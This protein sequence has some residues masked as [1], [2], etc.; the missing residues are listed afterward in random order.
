M[1]SGDHDLVVPF[2]STQAWIRALNYSIVDDWRPWFVNGQV[3][4]YTRTY[5]NGMTFSTVKGSG[6]TAAQYTPDQCSDAALENIII[7]EPEPE[8]TTT[9]ST[10]PE[11][12]E[13]ST[14]VFGQV[15][16]LLDEWSMIT[17]FEENDLK[18]DELTS[19][20][21]HLP[22]PADELPEIYDFTTPVTLDFSIYPNYWSFTDSHLR[23]Y[24]PQLATQTAAQSQMQQH[25]QAQSNNQAAMKN[26]LDF[27][28]QLLVISQLMWN[29]LT[30]TLAPGQCY[31]AW[32]ADIN[33]GWP[34][35]KLIKGWPSGSWRALITS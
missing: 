19:P 11:I 34:D 7:P 13:F 16:N 21:R 23:L 10:Y 32:S 4:G 28:Q 18:W 1:C 31:W 22:P 5:S 12:E 25:L 33:S 3:G 24:H 30:H 14:L 29:F 20:R 8:S 15:K 9:L 6:H 35:R 2:M 26:Q 27:I 17:S